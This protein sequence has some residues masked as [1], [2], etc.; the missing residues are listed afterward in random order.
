[1]QSKYPSTYYRVSIKAIIRNDKGEVLVV[2]EGGSN[3]SLPGGGMDHGE[4]THEA[5]KRELYEEVLVTS[6]FI[7][8]IVHTESMYVE[9]NQHWLLW[10]V[11]EV[12][13][14]ALEYGLGEH[15]DEVAFMD[16]QL[17]KDSSSR[18]ERLI[19]ALLVG[20]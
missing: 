14:E 15:A 1:M 8:K 16:P 10:I 17:F 4:T 6:P 3:W 12:E 2:K 18:S 5:L 20:D 19:H 9:E 11:Y 7:A 13:L